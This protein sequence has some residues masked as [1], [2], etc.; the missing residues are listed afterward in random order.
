MSTSASP[1]RRCPGREFGPRTGRWSKLEGVKSDL[2]SLNEELDP[3][4][5]NIVGHRTGE[6][7]QHDGAVQAQQGGAVFREAQFA[8]Q[9]DTAS[10]RPEP[11]TDARSRLGV[12]PPDD[13]LVDVPLDVVLTRLR[14][15]IPTPPDGR[16]TA[17]GPDIGLPV[18]PRGTS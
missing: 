11:G 15:R 16:V 4:V 12:L 14:S 17:L 3:G 18:A 6:V 5:L 9:L 7:Q 1:R 8:S 2:V 10:A 13:V